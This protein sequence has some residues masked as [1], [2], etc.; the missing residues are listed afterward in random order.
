MRKTYISQVN[1]ESNIDLLVREL[2]VKT[3]TRFQRRCTACLLKILTRQRKRINNQT[4]SGKYIQCPCPGTWI[5]TGAL[6]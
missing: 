3:Q 2:M 6:L 5:Q 1:L 4:K